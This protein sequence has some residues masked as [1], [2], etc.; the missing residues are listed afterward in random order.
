[1]LASL[2]RRL[3]LLCV[4]VTAVILLIMAVASLR[5][6]IQY[7]NEQALQDFNSGVA[8]VTNHLQTSLVID[9]TWLAQTEASSHLVLYLEDG[10]QSLLFGSRR[11]LSAQARATAISLGFDFSQ[12]PEG[13]LPHSMLFP[14]TSDSGEAFYACASVMPKGDGWLGMVILRSKA[15]EQAQIFR[16]SAT[17]AGLCGLAIA[18]LAVFAWLFTGRA[19]RPVAESRQKQ[20]FFLSAASHELKSPLAVIQ[21]TVSALETAPPDRAARFRETIAQECT[22][23]SRLIGDMLLLAGADNQ[24][25]TVQKEP[26]DLETLLLDTAEAFEPAALQKELRVRCSL[27]EEDCPLCR[28]D[29]MRVRQVLEIFLDNALSCTPQGGRITLGVDLPGGGRWVRLWVA[30]TGPGVPP[31]QRELV[32]DRFYQADLSR[33]RKGHWG[34]GL[35]IAAEIARLHRGRITIE[36]NSPQGAVFVLWLPR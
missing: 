1:M 10:G 26:T 29:R 2:R 12:K 33:S 23:M 35:S 16:L 11:D 34:L 30:D 14:F 4:T 5:I 6:S 13:L 8:S 18:A 36:D 27:P 15:P 31:Q 20:A 3:T 32:F 24:T 22:Q 9:H 25:W 21:S 19:I 28:C 17:F 7:L